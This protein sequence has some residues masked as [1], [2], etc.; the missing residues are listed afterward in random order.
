MTN[1]ELIQAFPECEKIKRDDMRQCI[2]E[3]IEQ[4][5]FYSEASSKVYRKARELY[6]CYKAPYDKED[7]EQNAY[8]AYFWS[9]FHGNRSPFQKWI[10]TFE[11]EFIERHG[12]QHTFDEACQM[13]ADEWA[14]MIFGTHMQNNGD[15]SDSGGLAMVLGTLVKDRAKKD[16]GSEVID[17][18]R[19]LIKEHYLGGCLFEYEDGKK[20]H[21][22]PDCDYHPSASLRQALKRAGCKD[23]DIENMCPWKTTILIDARDNSVVVRGYQTERYI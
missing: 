4:E 20:Y 23:D 8:R 1:E 10:D 6:P 9:D 19:S 2:I 7:P 11:T 18:F 12:Q 22:V 15:Q 13:A 21:D 5:K 16:Y 17:K 14:R 3:A